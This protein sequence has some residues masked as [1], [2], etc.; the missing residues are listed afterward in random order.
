MFNKVVTCGVFPM[1]YLNFSQVMCALL[2]DI[3]Q[4]MNQYIKDSTYKLIK[5]LT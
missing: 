1:R 5:A 3:R 4:K 2:N